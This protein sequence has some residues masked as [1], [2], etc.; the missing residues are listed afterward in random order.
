[1][2]EVRIIP[3]GVGDAFSARHYT[4][5]VALGAGDD[6]VLI[7]CPHPVRK[8]LREGSVAA[9]LPMD[10]DKIGAVL[11]SHLHADHCSGL[12]DWA[13]FA[14][15]HLGRRAEVLAHP[16]V[17]A[18]LWGGVLAGGM[19]EASENPDG[20]PV[21][22]RFDDFFGLTEL[23]EDGPVT[24]GPFSVECRKTHHLIPTTAF[25]VSALG[26][27]VGFSADTGYDPGL[28]DWLA[29]AD[30]IVHEAT[31]NPHSTVHTP[32]HRLAALPA[33]LRA[34]LRLIHYPDDFDPD[35][36]AIEALRQGRCYVV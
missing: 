14:H 5:C 10:L 21:P 24:F 4:T 20:P 19:G 33:A 25:R 29:P 22:R 26:R 9:G 35:A 11:L 2:A 6:W 34:K 30:L 18:K 32:Y 36:S 27:V 12:E 1:M 16:E 7:D 23:T 15:F 8:M 13:F 31:T 17:A 3:L 28:I